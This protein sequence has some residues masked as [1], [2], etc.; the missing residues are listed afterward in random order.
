MAQK[1]P[2]AFFYT[3]TRLCDIADWK[4]GRKAKTT[5]RILFIQSCWNIARKHVTLYLVTYKHSN[6]MD[7]V[8]NTQ[9]CKYTLLELLVFAKKHMYSISM[10]KQQVSYLCFV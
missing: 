4:I 8:L 7:A 2:C 6:A 5:N 9:A 10:V 3:N 1:V